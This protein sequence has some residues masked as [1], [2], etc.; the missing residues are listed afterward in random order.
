VER[1]SS[2]LLRNRLSD[3]CGLI[4]TMWGWLSLLLQAAVLIGVVWYTFTDGTNTA[5]AAW[6]IVAIVLFF[7]ITSVMFSLVCRVLTGRYPGQA[8]QARKMLAEFLKSQQTRQ[9]AG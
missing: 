2:E 3:L 1:F 7:W 4:L 9:G 8:K 5:V 6:F